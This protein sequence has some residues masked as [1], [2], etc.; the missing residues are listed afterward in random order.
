[1]KLRT[2]TIGILTM[3]LPAVLCAQQVTWLGAE[4]ELIAGPA[5]TDRRAQWLDT[6]QQWRT[7]EKKRLS[8][9]GN[10]Y[11]RKEFN[12][13][14]Q[15]FM[16]AQVMAHDRFLYDTATRQ[17]TVD[18]FLDDL[19]KRYGGL[20]GVLIWP[21]YPNIGIDNRNQFDLV[22]DM[23]G[24]KAGIQQMIRAFHRRGVKVF[25]PIMIW[26]HGTRRISIPMAA[27]LTGEMKELGADGLNGDTMNGVSEDFKDAYTRAG[28]PLVLQPEIHIGDLKMVEWNT[29]SW[30]YYWLKWGSPEFS[31]IPGVSV[32]KWLE[33]RH[34]VH[35]T[36]RWSVN[37]TDDLQYAFFNGVGYNTWENIWGIWNQLP[38]RYAFAIRRIRQI[39]RFFPTVWSSE[40]WEPHIL[41]EQPG[42]FAS[43]FP[44]NNVTVYTLVNRDSVVKQG[45][46]LALPFGAGDRYYDV[47]NGRQLKA[48][49]KDGKAYLD[50]SIEKNGFGAVALVK[51]NATLPG[52]SAFLGVMC[53]QAKTPLAG[54][55]GIS[56]PLQQRQTLIPAT[57]KYQQP[58]EGMV[59]IP[60]TDQYHFESAGVMI[61]GNEL[62]EAIGVQ[63]P[64]ESHP[65]RVH[66]HGMKLP[67]F[68]MDVYPVT[69]RQYK[70]FVQATGYHPA[71]DHHFLKDW[72]HGNYPDGWAEKPV[73][74]VSIEDAR[75]YATWAG[76][77]LPHEWE[78]QYA[79]Q[80]T[81]N[82]QY[83]W[84]QEADSLRIP[85][86]DTTRER[87]PPTNVNAYPA[88]A[89]PFGVKDL[90]GNVWQ[91]TDEYTDTHTRSA[92]LKGGSYYRPQTSYWYF[93]QTPKLTQHGKYLLVS[94]GMD[95][96]GTVGF[97]CVADAE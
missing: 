18:R 38:D 88:G 2:I 62:P 67:A 46:Q 69:N 93:P 58:P 13:V 51:N 90:T 92:V 73:T 29:M 12:W 26:D 40:N 60:G 31:Y 15:T 61:E 4:K 55:S 25:F 41:T 22:A 43:A 39:Y 21:T 28:Y 70:Q 36:D 47:W 33:P 71:D 32:Y 59:R 91:W 79:A 94:P 86:P 45:A 7:N 50:F 54:L 3:V 95:R 81:D 89:G 83:P 75:A 5:S 97:R 10:E 80:G 63:Y 65:Q 96:S 35:V 72:Q 44:G 9:N 11:S 87:R 84:G 56:L 14:Q 53:Q 30:G 77:R 20:D 19:E 68:Y 1:M 66:R 64:W 49:V 8:Y 42:V 57:K 6:L 85:V 76:K 48:T 52:L 34:Q 37:K 17:Y 16:F 82:R 78:W 23:P 27:A 24:G 74:W